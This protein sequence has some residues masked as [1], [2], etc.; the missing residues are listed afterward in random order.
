M[1]V[2][3]IY[4]YI[5]VYVLKYGTFLIENFN[6][7]NFLSAAFVA[8]IALLFELLVYCINMFCLHRREQEREN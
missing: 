3:I 8:V 5:C 1:S 4:V 7:Y 6:Q 2:S